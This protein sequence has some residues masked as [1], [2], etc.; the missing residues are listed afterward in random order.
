MSFSRAERRRANKEA[1][2][3]ARAAWEEIVERRS[4]VT[5]LQGVL[6]WQDSDA[7]ASR[8]TRC[9]ISTSPLS[10]T[11]STPTWTTIASGMDVDAFEAAACGSDLDDD[12]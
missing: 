9:P 4:L 5:E 6:Y 12:A 3:A 11:L 1:L 7:L 10:L 8:S 2:A